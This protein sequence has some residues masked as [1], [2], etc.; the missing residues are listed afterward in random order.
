MRS[1]L[2]PD[3]RPG[4]DQKWDPI[5]VQISILS[6]IFVYSCTSRHDPVLWHG[7]GGLVRL[8]VAFMFASVLLLAFLVVLTSLFEGVWAPVACEILTHALQVLVP[9]FFVPLL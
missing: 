2:G 9:R 1:D 4:F 6:C 7:G 8:V 5:L 3:F